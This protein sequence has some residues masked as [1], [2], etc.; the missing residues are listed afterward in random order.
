MPQY[1]LSAQAR[2]FMSIKLSRVLQMMMS[3]SVRL[4]AICEKSFAVVL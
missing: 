3:V 4:N 1:K 2:T